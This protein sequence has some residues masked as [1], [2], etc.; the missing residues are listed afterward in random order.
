M[1]DDIETNISSIVTEI[2]ED[3]FRQC[4]GEYRQKMMMLKHTIE[5]K[6]ENFKDVTHYT[7]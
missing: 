1:R 5:E 6:E 3:S 7:E 2:E 4:V